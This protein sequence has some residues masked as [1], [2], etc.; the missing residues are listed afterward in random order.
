MLNQTMKHV[1]S[2]EVKLPIDSPCLITRIVLNQHPNIVHAKEIK[3]KKPGALTLDYML[4]VGTHLPYTVMTRNQ[5]Q[6]VYKNSSCVS[7]SIKK[8]VLHELMEV[9]KAL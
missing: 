7:K 3:N 2:Y 1:D 9:S 5:G 4:I 6:A 8:D